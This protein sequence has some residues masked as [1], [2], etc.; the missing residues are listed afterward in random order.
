MKSLTTR[1]FRD[2]YR[3]LPKPVRR[4]ARRAYRLFLQNPAQ[5]GLNFKKIDDQDGLYSVRVGLGYR[6]LGKLDGP[7]VI[8]FWIGSHAEY[9]KRT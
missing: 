3:K 8:W 5:P 4:Q 2:A 6:A 7:D 1:Q 9:D